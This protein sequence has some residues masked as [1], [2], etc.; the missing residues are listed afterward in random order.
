M[1]QPSAGFVNYNVLVDSVVP[2]IVAAKNDR[3]TTTDKLVQQ[4]MDRAKDLF[5]SQL[6]G[7]FRRKMGF[8]DDTEVADPLWETLRSLMK[9]TRV[10][11]TLFFR[12]LTMVAATLDDFDTED[13]TTNYEAMLDSLIADGDQSP[14]YEP[15]SP[16][17]RQQYLQWIKEWRE[18]L[19]GLDTNEVAERMRMTNPKYILREWMMV[20]AYTAAANGDESEL[21]NLFELI[22]SPYD[23]GTLEQQTKY[24]RRTPDEAYM[25]A[26]TAFMSCSS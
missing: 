10:D 26:G 15:L 17:Y 9:I 22:Q 12:Q 19:L 7:V 8:P 2:V 25:A 5:E 14:F 16:E 20:N 4:F 6:D 13:G 3:A 1:N 23:E 24:Y 18:L 11:W 21:H